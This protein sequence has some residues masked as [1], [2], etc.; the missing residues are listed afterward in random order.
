MVGG[1]GGRGGGAGRE[2]VPGVD[3]AEGQGDGEF[4][5]VDEVEQVGEGRGGGEGKQAAVAVV[6][7]DVELED[8]LG[9]GELAE[10]HRLVH[11]LKQ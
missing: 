4:G 9:L 1:E 8:L 11:G 2:L 5:S 6:E 3:E 10:C 7:A